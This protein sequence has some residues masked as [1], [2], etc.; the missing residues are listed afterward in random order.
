MKQVVE[1]WNRER[2]R[3][4]ESGELKISRCNDW[5]KHER[6][7]ES[8]VDQGGWKQNEGNK[9]VIVFSSL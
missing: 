5:R 9:D 4:R 7:G 1:G 8:E 2:E 3:E 6:E